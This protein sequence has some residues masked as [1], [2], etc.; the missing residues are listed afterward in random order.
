MTFVA[1]QHAHDIG[2]CFLALLST[3]GI[4]PPPGSSLE[5]ELLSLIQLIEVMRNPSLVPR[6]DQTG[7]LR[8][9]AGLHDLAAKVLSVEH[10]PEFVT[11]IPHLRPPA[12]W[13]AH[14]K[15]TVV[16]PVLFLGQTLAYLPTAAGA[17]TPTALKM[18]KAY[19]ANGIPG[20]IALGL[21][22]VL[23]GFMQ[24][25]LLGVPGEPGRAVTGW[26]ARPPLPA[27]LARR[28]GTV[29]SS[30]RRSQGG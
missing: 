17:Q 30:C 9:A 20:P 1:F 29:K 27:R 22:N 18:L 7:V 28:T 21:A 5:D 8:A 19:D 13:E 12:E 11:F 2:H 23:N 16:R 24:T 25:I 10:I 15:R 26:H 6:P 4:Q 14:F 3:L